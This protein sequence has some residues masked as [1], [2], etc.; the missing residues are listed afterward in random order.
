MPETFHDDML[1]HLTGEV[2]GLLERIETVRRLARFVDDLTVPAQA[3]HIA[4][5]KNSP[6]PCPVCDDYLG[7]PRPEDPAPPVV[8][9]GP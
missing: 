2:N 6:A 4:T 8:P 3:A 1:N 7:N 5:A 9:P